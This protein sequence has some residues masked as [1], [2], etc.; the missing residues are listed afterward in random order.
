MRILTKYCLREEAKLFSAALF[1]FSGLLL[2]G[3]IM[4][5]LKLVLHEGAVLWNVLAIVGLWF[6]TGISYA[7]PMSLLFAILLGYG[8]MAQQ[9]EL[10]AIRAAG[11]LP[12]ELL[13]PAVYLGVALSAALFVNEAWI[14]PPARMAFR[15]KLS[16]VRNDARIENLI[17][18]G[19]MFAFGPIKFS[20][21]DIEPGPAPVFNNVFFEYA[22]TPSFRIMA[23]RA[24]VDREGGAP[25][26][27]FEKGQILWADAEKHL[28]V[29]FENAE[30]ALP[31]PSAA[32]AQVK[33]KDRSI[34]QLWPSRGVAQSNEENFEFHKKSALVLAPFF[35]SCFAS[36]LSML[37]KRGTRVLGFILTLSILAGYY[38][39]LAMAVAMQPAS[40]VLSCFFVWTPN[41]ILLAMGGFFYR[42]IFVV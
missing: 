32:A 13:S 42:L 37:I 26:F 1:F 7:I 5:L 20:C 24:R 36:T 4:N 19:Q 35:F 34:L 12:V 40:Q 33:P 14:A 25:K 28:S 10:T 31:E 38:I 8:R 18:P 39:L 23:A 9:E 17:P 30:H 3:Q 41:L 6:P 21:Q 15:E 2:L 16:A 11:V 22:G 29:Q 27:R